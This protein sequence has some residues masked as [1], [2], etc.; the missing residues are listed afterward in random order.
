[1][2]DEEREPAVLHKIIGVAKS[3]KRR[4]ILVSVRS[5]PKAEPTVW[6]NRIKK[7]GSA[8]DHTDDE[9]T[10]LG[11][12]EPDEIPELVKLLTEAAEQV[13]KLRAKKG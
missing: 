1:M 11:P 2:S 6:A 13:T 5:L 3:K 9:I 12:M 10:K 8:G 7:A 4:D